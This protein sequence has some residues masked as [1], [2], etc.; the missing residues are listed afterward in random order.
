MTLSS[1]YRLAMIALAL[2]AGTAG[3]ESKSKKGLPAAKDF[4]APLVGPAAIGPS[5]PARVDPHAG[6]P[7]APPI[8]GMGDPHAGVPGAPPLGGGGDPHAGVPGAPPLG[9]GDLITDDHAG[10]STVDQLGLSPPDPNRAIDTSKFLAGTV[11][12]A[13]ALRA[14]VPVG[15]T[16]F[17]SVRPAGPDG[18]PAGAPLAVDKLVASGTWPLAFRITEAKAMVEGTRFTGAVVV[19]ARFDQDG[20]ALRTQ[21]GDITGTARATIP[22]D[23]LLISLENVA[24]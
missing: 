2:T 16:I 5:A 14:K 11:T 23:G 19:A 10:G 20:E 12:V 18:K 17:L 4:Q 8:S 9:A 15:A 1:T 13:P 22:A 3:C 24:P 7:G 6:V 21:P